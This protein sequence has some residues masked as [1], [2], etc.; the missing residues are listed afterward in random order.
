MNDTITR[1]KPP[2]Y[3]TNSFGFDCP[4]PLANETKQLKKRKPKWQTY[5][6]RLIRRARKKANRYGHGD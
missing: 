1:K 3:S 6:E 2:E 4:Q 5:R